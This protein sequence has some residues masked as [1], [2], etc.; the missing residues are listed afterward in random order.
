VFFLSLRGAEVLF[1]QLSALPS[2]KQFMWPIHLQ[3]RL[4]KFKRPVQ[5]IAGAP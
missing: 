1:H 5:T 3:Y 2:G 4:E